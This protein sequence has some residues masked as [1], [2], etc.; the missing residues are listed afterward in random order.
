MG[1]PGVEPGSCGHPRACGA[2]RTGIR[3][4]RAFEISCR[5]ARLV[6]Y[7]VTRLEQRHPLGFSCLASVGRRYIT[8]TCFRGNSFVKVVALPLD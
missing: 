8:M 5:K 1:R 2:V 7:R 4:V 3:S 6:A